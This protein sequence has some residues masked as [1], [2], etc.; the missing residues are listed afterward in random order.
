MNV[1]LISQDINTSYP[2]YSKAVVVAET[3]EDARK[4]HPDRIIDSSK[5]WADFYAN[6]WVKFEDRELVKVEL[7]AINSII[8]QS[9]VICA[10]KV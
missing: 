8:G 3:E 5:P 2:A 6:D 10:E 7:I 9:R 4:I 1:Y